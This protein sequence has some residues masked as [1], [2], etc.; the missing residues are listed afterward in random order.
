MNRI[1]FTLLSILTAVSFM[2]AQDDRL[3]SLNFDEEPLPEETAPYSAVGVG[4]VV[5]LFMPNVTDLNAK[6]T[7]LGLPELSSP[8]LQFGAEFYTAIGVFPNVRVGFS[9]LTGSVNSSKDIDVSG[10]TM[11]RRMD[12]SVSSRTIHVDYALTVAPSFTILPGVGLSW[13]YTGIDLRTNGASFDWATTSGTPQSTNWQIERSAL[14][15]LP[16]VSF[17]YVLTPFLSIRAQGAYALQVSTSDWQ[18]NRHSTITNMPSSIGVN[19][20]S[21]HLGVFVGLFN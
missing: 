15:V 19:G 9:W 4:P 14:A 12:Y 20:F 21:A 5:N 2:Q 11:H 7:E 3:N 17:E 10:Q 8:F 16:R 18:A 6:A 13:A 1:I